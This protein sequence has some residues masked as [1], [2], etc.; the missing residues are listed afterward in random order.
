MSVA[1]EKFN[2]LLPEEQPRQ[3]SQ[4]RR[5]LSKRAIRKGKVLLTGCILS[6]FMVGVV[7]AYYYAQVATLGYQVA[8]LQNS[9]NQLQSE[10]EDLESQANQLKSL[11]RVEAI[12]TTKLGMVK[13]NSS[14]V[15][16]VTA[17]SEDPQKKL[18]AKQ[19][20]NPA[21]PPENHEAPVQKED[22]LS[23]AGETKS[24]VIEAFVDMV[25]RWERG[26]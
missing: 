20:V 11:E 17:L 6:V 5:A 16:L 18:E 8:Q 14:E 7:I 24:P 21:E 23:K 10:Q 15:V 19:G 13:P 1:Q 12:A 9:L 22:K 3:V 26:L 25:N 2:Y 4:P